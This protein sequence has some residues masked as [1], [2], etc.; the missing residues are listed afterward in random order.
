MLKTIS[1]KRKTNM[2]NTAV[3]AELEEGERCHKLQ[4]HEVV[5]TLRR[6]GWERKGCEAGTSL[7]GLGRR[8]QP[9]AQV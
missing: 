5:V 1:F 7:G 4:T 2:Q 9:A 3:L 6:A 8:L